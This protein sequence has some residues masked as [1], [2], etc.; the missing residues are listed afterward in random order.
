M[1][2]KADD[3]SVARSVH[4]LARYDAEK[5]KNMPAYFFWFVLGWFSVHDIYTRNWFSFVWNWVFLILI[6]VSAQK[7]HPLEPH[8]NTFLVVWIGSLI[9]D[10][11]TLPFAVARYNKKLAERLSKECQQ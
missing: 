10:F 9:F 1:K 8:F 4:A 11:L 2:V 3:L 5:K 7:G 6:F